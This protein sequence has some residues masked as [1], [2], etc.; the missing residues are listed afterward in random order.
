MTYFAVVPRPYASR[1]E[2]RDCFNYGPFRSGTVGG[3][4]RQV[5]KKY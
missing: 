5:Q 3:R 2:G 4:N 1:V